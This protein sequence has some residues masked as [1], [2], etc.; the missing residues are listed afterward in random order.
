MAAAESSESLQVFDDELWTLAPPVM[1]GWANRWQVLVLLIATRTHHQVESQLFGA[2]SY[3]N[4]FSLF[5]P[6][7]LN[8]PRPAANDRVITQS[9]PTLRRPSASEET[10]PKQKRPGKQRRRRIRP[11]P[12]QSPV[13]VEPPGMIKETRMPSPEQASTGVSRLQN[14]NMHGNASVIGRSTVEPHGPLISHRLEEE[15]EKN[16]QLYQVHQWMSQL[17]S[18]EEKREEDKQ[19][20]ARPGVS[21]SASYSVYQS[22][23]ILSIPLSQGASHAGEDFE[24]PAGTFSPPPCAKHNGYYC[25]YTEDYPVETVTQVT[26]YLKWPL[27][28]L[29]KDLRHLRSATPISTDGGALVCDSLTHAIR[30][31]WVKNTDGRWLV[32]LNTEEYEQHVTEVHCR[33]TT[34]PCNFIPPCYHA[35]CQ[36]RFNIQTLLVIDPINP[37][38]GPFLSKCLFPS[39]CVCRVGVATTSTFEHTKSAF[40]QDL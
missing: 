23:P 11:K 27:E 12:S 28:K 21:E 2:P 17:Q 1:F 25:P 31:G 36:Q 29:F 32:A 4:P 5:P 34:A 22:P 37:H 24:A 7:F 9:V 13:V 30:P 8:T 26:R 19:H 16:L 33:Y 18:N 39:C 40:H 3:Y 35:L 38:Q 20:D 14:H 10:A 15:K 6:P